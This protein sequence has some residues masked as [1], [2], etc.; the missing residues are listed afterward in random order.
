MFRNKSKFLLLS[1]L[2]LSTAGC[3]KRFQ[4]DIAEDDLRDHSF[5]LTSGVMND[6]LIIEFRDSTYEVF[7]SYY[8]EKETWKITK[9]KDVDF[10]ILN[11]KA[12]GIQKIDNHSFD[13]TLIG[14]IEH[15]FSL[16]Q[17]K[18]KWDKDLISGIWVKNTWSEDYDQVKNGNRPQIPPP[19]P[20]PGV[21]TVEDDYVWPPYFRIRKDSIEYFNYYTINTSELKI[22][23]TNE[24]LTMNLTDNFIDE[25]NDQ[26]HIKSLSDT[27]MVVDRYLSLDFSESIETD[28]LIKK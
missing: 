16:H 21:L 9:Y 25:Q 24:Y 20:P 8:Y 27:V 12:C 18:K 3:V 11:T 14:S 1:L 15:S 4:V 10:L 22:N 23:I 6:T 7:G 2:F 13:C 26:W 17:R 5:S 19:P 28:T